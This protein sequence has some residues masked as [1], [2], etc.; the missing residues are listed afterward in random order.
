VVEKIF[1]DLIKQREDEI[2]SLRKKGRKVIGYLCSRFPVELAYALDLIPIRVFVTDSS[3]ESLGTVFIWERMCP[4]AKLITGNFLAEDSFYSQNIDVLSGTVICQVVH[5]MLDVLSAYTK[6]PTLMLIYPLLRPP[7]KDQLELF[8]SE[9]QW[10]KKE[11]EKLSQTHL[12]EQKLKEAIELYDKVRK[13]LIDVY[14]SYLEER[15]NITYKDFIKLV[16]LSQ[17]LDPFEFLNFVKEVKK[18]A[19]SSSIK[20]GD[21][22][23]KI[24][25]SGSIILPENEV[26][27][28]LV[29]KCGGKIV[30]DDTCSGLRS[31]YGIE[32]KEVSISAI[33]KAY[34]HAIPCGATQCLDLGKDERLN[35]LTDIIKKYDIHGVI[36]Q[37]LRYCDPFSFKVNETQKFLQKVKS[38]AFL[39]IHMDVSSSEI[40]R[41]Q[42][43]IEAFIESIS[44]KLGG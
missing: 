4:Y 18:E 40:Q 19:G 25:I 10:L 41:L 24:L 35:F 5:R 22:K 44:F 9:V 42:T 30:A 12:T 32:V 7:E 13:E 6:K 43:R 28:D 1:F 33:A 38:V 27:L 8:T 37:T 31:F 26:I 2:K 34:L 15:L 3:Y 11:L 20:K 23:V 17:F 36:Y 16:L 14:E 29:E 21:N 39:P